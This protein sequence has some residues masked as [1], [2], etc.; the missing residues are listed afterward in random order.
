MQKIL[1]HATG[2]QVHTLTPA[3]AVIVSYI[4]STMV[5]SALTAKTKAFTRGSFLSQ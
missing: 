5:R 1:F 2:R 4:V 3:L